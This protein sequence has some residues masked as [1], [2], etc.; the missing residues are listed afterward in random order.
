MAKDSIEAALAGECAM[1]LL[2]EAGKGAE[3]VFGV[4]AVNSVEEQVGGVE[5]RKKVLFTWDHHL[6]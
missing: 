4:F 3:G 6:P 1:S 5:H 2:A